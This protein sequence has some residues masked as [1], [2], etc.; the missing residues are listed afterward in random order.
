MGEVV[1]LRRENTSTDIRDL[2]PSWRLALDQ[3][4]KSHHTIRSYTD[5]ARMLGDWLDANAR[6]TG[7]DDVEPEDI[8]VYLAERKNATS[9]GNA[10]K[11]FRNLR[12]FWKWCVSEAE[13]VEPNPMDRVGKIKV[14]EK[15]HNIFTDDD[16]RALLKTCS[17]SSFEDRR[18]TAIIRILIDNGVRVSGLAGLR[19]APDDESIHDVY[20]SRHRLRVR[21]KGGREFWAPIGK[22]AAAATDRY[23]RSRKRLAHE[24]CPWLWLPLRGTGE[25]DARLTASGIQQMLDRRGRQAGIKDVHPHR[26]RR[27]MASTWEGDSMQLMDIGGWQTLEM[28][29]L[30]SRAGRE[31]RAREA[32][33]RLSP[34][35][36]I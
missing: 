3:E 34:G 7:V 19:Y 24:D 4:G 11:D 26:F 23:I 27:T 33:S 2:I 20:L 12:V 25:V 10:A 14:A 30:Y 28:V 8:R 1:P 36:R 15:A 5:T 13:R 35:D 17:G 18:D 32:H 16:L 9:A 31:E 29:R 21:L 22:K 6:P